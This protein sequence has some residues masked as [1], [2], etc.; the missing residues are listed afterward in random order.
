MNIYIVYFNKFFD[1]TKFIY[2][3]YHCSYYFETTN[4]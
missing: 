3:T 1:I 4:K 2:Y